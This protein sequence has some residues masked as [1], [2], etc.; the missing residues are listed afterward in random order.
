MASVVKLS[1]KHNQTI[2]EDVEVNVEEPV[3]VLRT[4]LWTLTGVHPERQKV[5]IKGLLKDDTN[6]QTLQ[7]K[8]GQ[9]IVLIGTSEGNEMKQPVNAP[10]FIEDLSIQERQFLLQE[11]KIEPLPMGLKN[12]GNTCFL[13]SVLQ[14]LRP[15]KKLSEQLQAYSTLSQSKESK[16]LL[17]L[18]HLHSIWNISCT[19]SDLE[20]VVFYFRLVF[21]QLAT[22]T[23][24]GYSQ[25]DAEQ[26][27]SSLLNFLK[28]Q[29]PGNLIDE[30]F[31]IS[32]NS[33]I[34]C[35]EDE[36]ELEEKGT[37]N[38]LVLPCHL[39]AA[40]SP[41]YDLYESIKVSME[42]SI[43]KMSPGLG[44]NANYKKTTSLSS[45]PPFLLVQFVRFEWKKAQ[46]LSKAGRAKI[47][48]KLIFPS[49]LDLF[50]FCSEDLQKTYSMG[51]NIIAARKDREMHS[52][53]ADTLPVETTPIV[54]PVET[55]PIVPPVETAPSPPNEIFDGKYDLCS[56]VTHRG[57]AAESG[58]YVGWIKKDEEM[59]LKFD[60]DQ[61]SL[62]KWSSIDLCGGRSDYHIAYLCMYKRRSLEVSEE[63]LATIKSM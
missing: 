8:D 54:P 46:G 21:P 48:R 17:A 53:A 40:S 11:N 36:E 38:F 22:H 61:V 59:W 52:A 47:C 42:S 14:F 58:H 9:R 25:Q 7:L 30:L 35:M 63:E 6:L 1:V 5:L 29:L 27:L 43:E 34:K 37:E 50:D 44:R 18:K 10:V 31:A 23:K 2:Y 51:R 41:V 12:F 15:V 33:S 16:F 56:I 28:T 19:P 3:D 39:S 32:M 13:N 20:K 49:S 60:D 24:I 4:Q 26:C 45:L 62:Q 57:R 55:T